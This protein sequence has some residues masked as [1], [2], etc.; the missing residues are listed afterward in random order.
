MLALQNAY[1]FANSRVFNWNS[2]GGVDGCCAYDNL[3]CVDC[4]NERLILT[5]VPYSP[6]YVFCYFSWPV[7]WHCI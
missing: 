5:L 1:L 3:L 2:E 7:A 4:R 6:L